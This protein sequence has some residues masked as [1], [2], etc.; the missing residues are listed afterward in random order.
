M[1]L[2]RR[3]FIRLAGVTAVVAVAVTACGDDTAPGND[4]ENPQDAAPIFI[5][6]LYAWHEITELGPQLTSMAMKHVRIGGEMSD[7]VMR[8]CATEQLTVLLNF[9]P[10]ADRT[11]FPSDSAFIADYISGVDRSLNTYG[12]NGTFWTANPQLPQRPIAEVEIC[13]EPNFG[14]GFTGT[15]TQVAALYAKLLVATYDHIKQRW[16]QLT[17]VAFAAGGASNAAPGFLENALAALKSLNRLDSFDVA[18]LHIYT[19]GIPPEQQITEQ[20]GTWTAAESLDDAGRALL[21]AGVTKPMWITEAGYQISQRDGGQFPVPP[22]DKA[23]LPATVTP[24]QQAAYTVRLN[25]IV[26][27]ARLARMYHMFAVDTDGYNGGWFDRSANHSARPVAHAMGQFVRLLG[28]ATSL[29]VVLDGSPTAPEL[30]FAYR[31]VTP[32]G[33]IVIAWAQVP[34]EF[35]LETPGDKTVVLDMYGKEI[36]TT[37]DSRYQAALTPSPIYLVPADAVP[38]QSAPSS[39]TR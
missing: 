7:D 12:P 22:R 32:R 34:G 3:E 10:S 8:F 1:V 26:A 18:S 2:S 14:Y 36:T 19:H 16:P 25:I 24:E 37:S 31:M 17:V 28:D 30:P 11:T 6:G 5:P 13:N 38:D 20:W 4:A 27:R 39:R 21:A 15:P 33:D 23:G 9:A 29:E 35:S